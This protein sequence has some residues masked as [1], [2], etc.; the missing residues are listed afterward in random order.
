MSDA[1]VAVLKRMGSG[2]LEVDNP[3]AYGTQVIKSIVR[4]TLQGRERDRIILDAAEPRFHP[5]PGVRRGTPALDGVDGGVLDGDGL[6]GDGLEG[7][8]L[9]EDAVVDEL[10]VIIEVMQDPSLPW[11]TGAALAYVTLATGDSDVPDDVP[12]PKA[13]ATA[14]QARGWAALWFA[15]VRDVFP[16]PA[17]DPAAQRRRRGRYVERVLEHLQVAFDRHRAQRREVSDA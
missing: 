7:D 3:A 4:L 10:R 2:P 17:G 5:R 6:D 11:L 9:E 16:G 12:Q 1:Q 8:G 13:G 15:G 14:L